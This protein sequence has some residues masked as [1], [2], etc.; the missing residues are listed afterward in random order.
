MSRQPPP[1]GCESVYEHLGEPAIENRRTR[2]HAQLDSAILV[3]TPLDVLPASGDLLLNQSLLW[4]NRAAV[5]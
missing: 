1:P 4:E 5:L 3:L 2:T